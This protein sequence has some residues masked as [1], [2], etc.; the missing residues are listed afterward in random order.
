MS[1]VVSSVNLEVLKVP[2]GFIRVLQLPFLI[3][4]LASINGWHLTLEYTCDATNA[5]RKGPYEVDTFNFNSVMIQN[6]TDDSMPL[7]PASYTANCGFFVFTAVISLLFV[8]AMLFIYMILWA[9]YESDIR[10][11]KA[12]FVGTAVLLLGWVIATLA[13]WSGEGG[14]SARTSTEAL[15][16]RLKDFCFDC[17]T[18]SAAHN[19]GILIAVIAGWAL[20]MLFA[21][22]LWFT[23]KETIWFRNR[24][25]QQQ[26]TAAPTASSQPYQ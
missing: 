6:C 15:N 11:P 12:D 21:A 16:S 10:F 26:S 24:H 7:Y 14:V 22:D 13:W 23:Y 25:Q 4:A 20:V 18:T 8:F 2:L 9:M 3:L 19:G 17:T 1:S 5:T